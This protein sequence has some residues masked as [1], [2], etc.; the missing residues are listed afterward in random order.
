MP[1]PYNKPSSPAAAHHHGHEEQHV[2]DYVRTVYKRRWLAI[3]V[4]LVVAVVGILNAVREIPLYQARTQLMIE[5]DTPTVSTL[6]QMFQSGDGWYND[7]FYQTQY[8]ILQ[9]RSLAKKAIDELKMW[10]Q[11][12][13]RPVDAPMSLDPLTLART[14][15]SKIYH[16]V[17]G[18]AGA[19][20]PEGL[21]R[22]PGH[23]R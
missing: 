10:D 19:D 9:S 1:T 23:R 17:K 12:L 18:L 15:A 2:M 21:P 6:D 16:G 7:A 20:E 14:G 11:P 13:G 5:K 4:F 22:H 8:R 3:P